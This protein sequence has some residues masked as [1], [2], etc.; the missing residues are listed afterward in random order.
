MAASTLV[1][2]TSRR[3]PIRRPPLRVAEFFA[4]IGLVRLALESEGCEVVFLLAI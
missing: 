4:G 1:A 3:K 2:R